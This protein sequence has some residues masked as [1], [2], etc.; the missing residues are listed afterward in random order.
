MIPEPSPRL[1]FLY[2]RLREKAEKEG[3]WLNGVFGVNASTAFR[4][5]IRDTPTGCW[6]I[7]RGMCLRFVPS[8]NRRFY[9]GRIVRMCPLFVRSRLARASVRS[10]VLLSETPWKNGSGIDGIKRAFVLVERA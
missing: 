2:C 1:A 9:T 10:D 4:M 5:G 8:G 3:T 7:P 6:S